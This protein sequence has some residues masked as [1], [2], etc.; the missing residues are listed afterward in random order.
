MKALIVIS[1]VSLLLC[2]IASSAPW[3]CRGNCITDKLARL[4]AA[5]TLSECITETDLSST[6]LSL[7]GTIRLMDSIDDT[8]LSSISDVMT[9]AASNNVS[10]I[11]SMLT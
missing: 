10:I 5:L 6:A 2:S 3:F 11:I 8:E 7:A 1:I 4:Q 9:E